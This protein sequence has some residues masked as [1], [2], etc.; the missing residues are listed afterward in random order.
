MSCFWRFGNLCTKVKDFPKTQISLTHL[1]GFHSQKSGKTSYHRCKVFKVNLLKSKSI[2]NIHFFPFWK[3]NIW[4]TS[5]L[6]KK[7]TRF[8]L[9]FFAQNGCN[10]KSSIISNANNSTSNLQIV[11]I[12]DINLNSYGQKQANLY[13][14]CKR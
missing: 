2:S 7:W 6:H 8:Y 12:S 1:R 4:L 10:S 9:L 3:I 5:L 13:L 14:I 11:L